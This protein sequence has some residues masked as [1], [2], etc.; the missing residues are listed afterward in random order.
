M[1]MPFILLTAIFLIPALLQRE[2]DNDFR[3]RELSRKYY[4]IFICVLFGLQS[5]LRGMSVGAD[6]AQYY[7][8][9]LI[10]ELTPFSTIWE[11]FIGRFWEN[12]N[13][14]KDPGYNLFTKAFQFFSTDYQLFLLFVAA[15]FFSSLGY[16]I[17][18]NTRYIQDAVF[19][20]LLYLLIFYSFFSVTGIRQTLATAIWMWCFE[21]AKRKKLVPFL[22][23][24]VVA[25]MFHNSTVAVLPAYFIIQIR[26]TYAWFTTALFVF[27]LIMLLRVPFANFLGSLSGYESDELDTGGAYT[28]TLLCLIVAIVA[29]F[30]MIQTLKLFPDD[31]RLYNLFAV[32]IAFLPLLWVHPMY[33]RVIQYYS[34]FLMILFPDIL[35]S[36]YAHTATADQAVYRKNMRRAHIQYMV[37]CFTM[38]LFFFY[39]S[40]NYHYIFFWQE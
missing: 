4:I 16:F 9:F 37:V 21:L 29:R 22:L 2:K 1:I 38:A 35:R 17:Y 15:I 5:G 36:F 34:I 28:F 31:A 8:R 14:F 6:T 39:K 18:K 20:F 32:A 11:E 40:M 7:N 27:P 12:T 13:N 10:I 23:L 30:R 3:Q 19:A 33:M 24:W 25:Y 26:K